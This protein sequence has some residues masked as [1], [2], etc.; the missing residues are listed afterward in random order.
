MFLF[1]SSHNV[2]TKAV[3]LGLE[4]GLN[5]RGLVLIALEAGSPRSRNQQGRYHSVASSLDW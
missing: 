2:I 3:D 5:D 1:Y 4:W